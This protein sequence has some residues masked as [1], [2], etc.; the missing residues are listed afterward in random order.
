MGISSK[1][2]IPTIAITLLVATAILV[3]NIILFSSFVDT[4]TINMVNS[5]T[6]VALDRL[7]SLKIKSKTASLS[8]SK[9]SGIIDAIIDGERGALLARARALQAEIGIEFCAITDPEGMVLVRTHAPE[10][11]G[12]SI[13]SQDNIQSAMYGET[14][15]AVE[16]GSIIR[17][18]VRSGAPVFDSTNTL[19]GVVSVGFRLD[20]NEFVDSIKNMMGCEVNVLLGDERIASTILQ[21]DG[22]RAVGTRADA[23]IAELIM[24]G[25]SFSGRVDI[26]GHIA[27][28]RYTP[29]YGPDERPLGMLFI[30]Q[31]LEE[32]AKTIWAFVQS[33]LIITFLLLL[34][35]VLILLVITRHIVM[36]IR[37]MTNSVSAMA[38]GDTDIDIKVNTH[39]E[40]R[41][42]ADAFNSM[43][44]DTRRQVQIIEHI[45]AGDLTDPP[46]VRSEKDIMNRALEKLN[47]TIQAQTAALKVEHER[48]QLMLDANPLA[49][50]MWDRNYNLI[51]CNEAAVKLFGLKSKQEYI[52]RY[53]ELSPVYQPDGQR[54]RD[55]IKSF[56]SEAFEKGTCT[57]DW[58]YQMADGTPVPAEIT[59]VR[60]PYG[61]DYVVAAYSRDLREQK[62]MMAEIEQRDYLLQVVNQAAD[63]L[64]RSE[65]DDFAVT[66]HKCM[67]MMAKAI[68]ADRMYL[69]KNHTTDG[70]LYCT[71]IYEWSENVP[72]FISSGITTNVSYDERVPDFKRA[73]LNGEC[74]NKLVRSTSPESQALLGAQGILS[75]LAVPI[76]VRDQFWGFV[77]FDNCHSERLFTENQVSVMRSGSMLIANAFL[78]NEYTLSIKDTS[79]QLETALEE[80]EK[81]NDA[82][83]SFL[84]HM[85]HEMRTPLSA[86]VGLS[87]LALDNNKLSEEVEGQLEKIHSSGMT[88]LSIVNDILDISKIESGKFELFPTQ[89]DTPSLLN[90]IVTL[91]AVRI[92]EK[93]ITFKLYVDENLPGSLY[94]DDLRVKQVFNNILSNAFKYTNEGTVEW[95]VNFEL[96]G[97]NIW[98]VSSI[99]D[100]GIGI[101]HENV[102]K[103]FSEYGQ[104]DK[105]THRKIEGTG[106]GL[107]ITKRLVEMMDGTITVN[108][109]YGQ[110]TTVN[111]RLRQTFIAGTP[112][113]G[114][115]VA[116]NIM[117]SRYTI[118]KRKKNTKLVRVDLSYANV[119]VVDDILTNLDVVKGMMKP[120]GL[121]VD[122]AISGYQA[123]EMIRMENPRYS[124]V[125]MDL[126]MPGMDGIEAKRI[127]REEIGTDYAK[128]IPIIAL[129]ANAIV[130]NEEMFLSQGFQ[131]FI[132]KPIDMT[133]LDAVLRRWVRDKSLEKESANTDAPP[134]ETAEPGNA[135]GETSLAD[136]LLINGVDKYQAVER[137][138][139]QD[140]FID[141]LRSYVVNT[142]PLLDNLRDY[143][144]AGN[145]EDYKIVI[146]GI[147]G[148][149][150]AI[151]AQ[152]AGKLAEELEKAAKSEDFDTVRANHGIFEKT[153]LMLL[154]DIDQA[155]KEIN[156]TTEKPL[157]AEPD[158]ELLRELRDACQA[159]DMDRVDAAMAEL[160]SFRYRNGEGLVLW[161]REQVDNMAFEEI[162][163]MDI[164]HSDFTAPD[165][166]ILIVDDNETNLKAAAGM[167]KPLQMRIDTAESGEAALQMIQDK[168][169]H[170]IFMDHLMPK[171]DGIE[172]TIKLRQ[173]KGD[174]YLNVPVIAL[175]ANGEA[176]IR[177]R[178]LQAGMNDWAAKPILM[179]EIRGKI[180]RWLPAE[181][182]REENPPDRAAAFQNGESASSADNA[183][184][185]ITEQ[186]ADLPVIE[187]IDTQEGILHAGTK[188]LF[189]SLLGYFY[190]I[191]DLK[192]A[193]IENCLADGLIRDLTIEVHALATNAK[194][195]GA[196]ELAEGFSR[197][198]RYGNEKNSEALERETPEVLRQYRNFK[199]ILE[200]FAETA[201]QE[202]KEASKETLISLLSSIQSSMNNYDID[203][204]DKALKQLEALQIPEECRTQMETLRAYVADVSM[205]AAMELTD[206]MIRTIEQIP[207]KT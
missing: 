131:D 91:N 136:R 104:I 56:V 203:G 125:F 197:L 9:D 175:T 199:S 180:K 47:T 170:L 184:K 88:L 22:L 164:P 52:D 80:A 23:H 67:G 77:G 6:E 74:V 202:K 108:S 134:T 92:G 109:T 115:T 106:L 117:S 200:P 194:M 85:S 14:M 198:E 71:Q 186:S 78:R 156:V 93:P 83:S 127:I 99:R 111:V 82:K 3:S 61:N 40:M 172:T 46:K 137:F 8:I 103:L 98:I 129:T 79:E 20:T 177:E 147:K 133:K 31:Y 17:M 84:A 42:L 154:D 76:S 10:Q 1:I 167:L 86:V 7:D 145:F 94:G 68:D 140:V 75:I 158:T 139:S 120:Y 160:E 163:S 72:S 26:L 204:A 165:A 29:I 50:R 146:H 153:E 107:A 21:E 138:G 181:L 179:K 65:P 51:E 41:I 173:M 159:F 135:G 171:M 54:T 166:E 201:A 105:R 39:D 66:L 174:Y 34:V 124:A 97:S 57:Y 110:G 161:L 12:D 142:R 195:I 90:D 25:N 4:S 53:F 27:V 15:T 24:N 187:G 63:I 96:D 32:E 69:F 123:I 150:Y 168:Q 192:A 118:S 73:Y 70:K 148:S 141:V 48:V 62:K 113:I 101:K 155:L 37:L 18:S 206:I 33:G 185:Q 121:K 182:L 11:Y 89:Y 30:G 5:A 13:A 132:S 116:D 38:V 2:L 190:K 126:M 16:E 122:C 152:E 130:G 143:L 157:A 149:S 64:F 59:M 178:F 191:I 45:A 19:V 169:Y 60:V 151:F 49:S 162:S 119:L 205:E 196:A 58:M 128:N 35:S 43:I 44:D 100:T 188:E 189:V 193:K 114:K 102:E 87:E 95:R 144:A 55:K 207:D 81:A 176:G 28:A 112:P 36:P 183:D